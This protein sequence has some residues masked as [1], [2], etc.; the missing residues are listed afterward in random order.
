M[1]GVPCPESIFPEEIRQKYLTGHS[2]SKGWIR[3]VKVAISPGIRTSVGPSTDTFEH[4]ICCPNKEM[5]A[6]KMIAM[7]H[8]SLIICDTLSYPLLKWKIFKVSSRCMLPH[9]SKNQF[10]EI[11]K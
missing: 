5:P 9:P 7:M 11:R 2:G 8:E 4:R 3:D 10:P 1:L 6:A